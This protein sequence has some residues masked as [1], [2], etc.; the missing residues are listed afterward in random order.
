MSTLRRIL[1][2]MAAA[3]ALWILAFGGYLGH[4]AIEG[5]TGLKPGR[6]MIV[7]MMTF[8]LAGVVLMGIGLERT[9]RRFGS[10][11]RWT[12][13]DRARPLRFRPGA[14]GWSLW[15]LTFG[16]IVGHAL[17]KGESA[18]TIGMSILV[19]VMLCAVIGFGRTGEL[20]SEEERIIASGQEPTQ[21]D[22][23]A[24]HP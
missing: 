2:P 12:A 15:V 19:P 8:F 13:H 18:I 6:A 7:P 22:K 11:R 23:E 1:I 4:R 9:R 24:I 3:L 21:D 16:M 10:W 17:G 14:L 20:S 5:D